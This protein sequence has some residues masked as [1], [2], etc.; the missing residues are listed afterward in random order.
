M[1][2]RE[3]GI[4]ADNMR[5]IERVRTPAEKEARAEGFG[6]PGQDGD[7]TGTACGVRLLADVGN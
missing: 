4:A 2:I 1:L 7:R 3:R 6:R 5:K